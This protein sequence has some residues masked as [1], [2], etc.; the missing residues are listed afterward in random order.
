MR[1]VN[2][3]FLQGQLF[4]GGAEGEPGRRAVDRGTVPCLQVV[5][6]LP[7]ARRIDLPG[8]SALAVGEQDISRAGWSHEV[9]PT[10]ISGSVP[11]L[12]DYSIIVGADSVDA[13]DGP[14]T[15]SR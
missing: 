3:R 8:S 10:Q 7:A 6:H 12:R 11:H 4:S 2:G 14:G 9:A 5:G 1:G 15:S 13:A